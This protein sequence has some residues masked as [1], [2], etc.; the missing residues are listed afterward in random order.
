MKYILDS[1]CFITPSRTFCPTDVGIS[2]WNKIKDLANTS[3]I[4]SIDKVRDELYH[5]E[6]ALKSWM[7]YNI[8]RGFFLRFDG[9]SQNI[10]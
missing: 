8:D 10:Q 1:N 7:S 9:D 2:F 5:N 3:R 6:D 4:Y